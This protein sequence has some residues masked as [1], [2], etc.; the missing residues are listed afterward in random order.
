[1]STVP[2]GVR[3]SQGRQARRPPGIAQE[4]RHGL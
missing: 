4:P 3:A 1:M 2:P